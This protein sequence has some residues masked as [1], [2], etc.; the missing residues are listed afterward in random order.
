[1][2]PRKPGRVCKGCEEPLGPGA[3]GNRLFCDSCQPKRG[4]ERARQHHQTKRSLEGSVRVHVHELVYLAEQQITLARQIAQVLGPLRQLHDA[5]KDE[6]VR[7]A[8]KAVRDLQASNRQSIDFFLGL[9]HRSGKDI[10]RQPVTMEGVRPEHTCTVC[11]AAGADRL[12]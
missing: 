10:G 7:E 5:H 4:A 1:M 11:Q 9:A 12:G 2:E 6:Q 3:H 8:I